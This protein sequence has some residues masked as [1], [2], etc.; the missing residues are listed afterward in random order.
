ME[1]WT[2]ASH[3]TF[4][5]AKK[6]RIS[7]KVVTRLKKVF[8]K[9]LIEDTSGKD[10]KVLAR[11]CLPFTSDIPPIRELL[12]PLS[13]TFSASKSKKLGRFANFQQFK[14]NIWSICY[15]RLKNDTEAI[16]RYE[17]Y[18]RRLESKARSSASPWEPSSPE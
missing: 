6:Q 9:A 1:I 17:Q 14:L 18:V 11:I 15:L 4:K 10:N 2:L 7:R 12:S 16:I 3:V 13:S 5:L 8:E